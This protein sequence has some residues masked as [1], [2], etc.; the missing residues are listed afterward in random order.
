M[1]SSGRRPDPSLKDLLFDKAY[2]FEF[3]QAVRLLARMFPERLAIGL[4]AMPSQELV[5]FHIHQS[6]EFPASQVRSLNHAE[7]DSSPAPMT[8]AFMGLTGPLGVLPWHYTEMLIQLQF[9]KKPE[10]ADFFDLF[11]H[12]MISLFYR[13]WEKHHFFVS[14]ERKANRSGDG[15]DDEFTQYLFD[16]VGMGTP[17]L[18]G[19]MCISDYS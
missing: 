3:F 7:L 4:D 17:G 14:Y 9:E 6:M 18:R 11:N 10:L 12:R 1:A 8:L 13:A 5:R 19:R 15:G 16:L 2:E